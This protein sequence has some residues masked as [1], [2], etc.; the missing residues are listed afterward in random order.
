ML[1]GHAIR[2]MGWGKEKVSY[3]LLLTIVIHYYE[4]MFIVSYPCTGSEILARRK[5]LE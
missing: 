3:S 2:I 5:Q 1:G 4:Q